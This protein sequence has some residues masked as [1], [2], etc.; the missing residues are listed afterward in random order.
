V[1]AKTSASLEVSQSYC[2]YGA[3]KTWGLHRKTDHS[4]RRRGG[5]SSEHVHVW[6]KQ[7][8]W[9]QISIRPEAKI[10]S[11][12]EG[13]QQ[14]YHPTSS[15]NFLSQKLKK[16]GQLMIHDRRKDSRGL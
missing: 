16:A 8:S 13:Q 3:K 5:P 11:A 6:E 15:G 10:D 14:F 1:L 12:G 7:K 2:Y 9:L 4:A